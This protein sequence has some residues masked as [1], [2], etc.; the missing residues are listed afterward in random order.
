MATNHSHM[1]CG[2]PSVDSPLRCESPWGT[3]L[4]ALQEPVRE[5]AMEETEEEGR[6]TGPLSNLI[7]SI[8][9]Q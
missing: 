5:I 3:N 2:V 8:M 1:C 7:Y 9:S 4:A 6:A